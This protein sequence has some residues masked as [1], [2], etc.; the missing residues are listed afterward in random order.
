MP[1]LFFLIISQEERAKHHRSFFILYPMN[2]F[3]TPTIASDHFTLSEEESKHCVRVLRMGAGE[4]LV[5]VDGRGGFY[6][7]VIE[8]ADPKK[9]SVK[10]VEEQKEFGKRS[11][12][13]HIACAPTKNIERFEWF[14]EKATEMGIDGITPL[15]CDHSE[16]SSVKNERLEKVIVS[17]MKQSLKAY[18]PELNEA[19]KFTEMIKM[20]F[21][22][23]K[24]IAHCAE[25]EKKHLKELIRPGEKILILIGPEGDFSLKEIEL[26]L[27][28]GFVQVSLGPSRLRTETAALAA[29]HTV[30]L[31]NEQC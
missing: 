7:A 29:C 3:Y 16:R 13:L 12:F 6:K 22:G 24:F 11:H 18:L 4:E 23:K 30:N 20:D 21:D 9:C 19:V 8:N 31:M 2:V 14:L 26:A 17:A 15:I 5:L 1:E 10:I 28:N 25:G 27:Q